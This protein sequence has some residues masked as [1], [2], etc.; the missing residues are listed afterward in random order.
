MM[1]S[2]KHRE[3]L[4]YLSIW[5]TVFALPV[6]T[7][8]GESNFSWERVIIEW[9]RILPFLLIFI[10]NNNGLVP[11]FLFRKKNLQYLLILT[12]AVVLISLLFDNFRHIQEYLMPERPPHFGNNDLFD[13]P[14]PPGK[15]MPKPEPY[16]LS[17]MG[18]LID[19]IIISY[20]V[21][22]FNTAVKFVFK[23]QE[24]EKKQEEQKKIHLQTEL[25]FL[26]Q[27]ISP[28]FFMNTLN[29]IHALIEIEA[30][31][32]Q[33]AII[34]LSK[35]MRYLLTESQQGKAYI[36]DEFDFLNSYIDLMRLRYSDR[37]K[38]SVDLN[39]DDARKKIPTLLFVS[40]VENAF[41]Y[42]ISYSK[43]SFITIWAK[44]QN[45]KLIFNVK[46]SKS[47]EKSLESGTGVGLEN[48]RKQLSLLFGANFSFEIQETDEI[49]NVQLQIPLEND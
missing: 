42:G 16:S 14:P 13:R 38:I 10:L 19:R 33:A 26:R 31:H 30:S 22:G 7:L 29:N 1:I 40:L 41:K 48:L 28:H 37:V 49:F 24:E 18:R 5:L 3:N 6:F 35:L 25:S 43:P 2:K 11:F 46:N 27:Q 12:I 4:I 44:M 45:N 20:L 47:P 17:I 21:V 9:F 39:I 23:H 32:A 15:R 36:K 34:K 8:R